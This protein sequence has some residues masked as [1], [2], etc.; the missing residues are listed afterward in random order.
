MLVENMS[1]HLP[2]VFSGE[3]TFVTS[4]LALIPLKLV[5][6]HLL[7]QNVPSKSASTVFLVQLQ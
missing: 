7:Q 3:L 2:A 6:F 4:F 5:Y 1:G